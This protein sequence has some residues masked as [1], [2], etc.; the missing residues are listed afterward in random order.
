VLFTNTETWLLPNTSFSANLACAVRIFKESTLAQ[1]ATEYAR[2]AVS[3]ELWR[4]V[5]RRAK[6]RSLA[7]VRATYASADAV[8]VKSGRTCIV[9]NIAGNRF[10]LVTAIHYNRN[11]IYIL[12]FLTHSEYSK[13]TWKAEL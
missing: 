4:L 7:D 11:R 12:K 8:M 5:A 3:L 10:R 13:D 9:F 6:W 2:A 1:Y